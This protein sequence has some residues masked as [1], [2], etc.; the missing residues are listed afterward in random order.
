S[1]PHLPAGRRGT[2]V[3]EPFHDVVDDPVV[4]G[5]LGAEPV[6][7]QAV[8]LDPVDRL[9]GVLRDQPRHRG[10]GA[11]ELLGVDLDVGA[12]P[13]KPAE[14][15]CISTWACGRLNRLPLVPAQ[16]RNWPMLPAR[17]MASV[18]TSLGISCIAS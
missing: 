13:P 10:P 16:S 18:L 3:V 4:A 6:V 8:L 7:P 1:Q 15:W 9:P 11:F 17:P 2:H 12:V 5:L 14:P